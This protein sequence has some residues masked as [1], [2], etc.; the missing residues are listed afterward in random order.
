MKTKVRTRTWPSG[1]ESD[2]T[3]DETRLDRLH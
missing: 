2:L 3:P 1:P